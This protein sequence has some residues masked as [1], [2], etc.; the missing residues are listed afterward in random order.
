MKFPSSKNVYYACYH[1]YQGRFSDMLH[2]ILNFYHRARYSN[3]K[4]K[5]NTEQTEV[6][7]SPVIISIPSVI[8][9]GCRPF[10]RPSIS[11]VCWRE[12]I[13]VHSRRYTQRSD[14]NPTKNETFPFLSPLRISIHQVKIMLK[15]NFKF[16]TACQSHSHCF[17]VWT[18]YVWFCVSVWARRVG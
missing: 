6:C 13:Q 15:A 16:F 11:Y 8:H 17:G 10:H 14:G 3:V 9:L 2:K 18:L 12:L 7:M 5:C 1:V 4:Y